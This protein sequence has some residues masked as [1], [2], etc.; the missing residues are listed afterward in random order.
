YIFA[1]VITD[2][3]PGFPNTGV[4]N[5]LAGQTTLT[6]NSDYGGPTNV[7]G[8]TLIVNGSIASSSMTTVSSG[9]VLGGIGTVGNTIVNGTIA[10]GNGPNIGT[11]T[12]NGNYTQNAGSIYQVKVGS[13]SDRINVTGNATINGG[14]VAVR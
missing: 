8:G 5:V 13:E 12:V 14:T 11:L 9:A 1:P 7:I 6:A 2:T 10:P 3:A 4:V